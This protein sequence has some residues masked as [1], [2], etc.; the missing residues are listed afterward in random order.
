MTSSCLQK[1]KRI[2]DS[3]T[4]N[5]NIQS[6]YRN[7]IWHRK[8][9]HARNEKRKKTKNG[10]NKTVKWRKNQNARRIG[11]LQVLGNIGCR[12]HQTEIRFLKYL[13]RVS[14]ANEKASRNQTLQQESPQRKKNTWTVLIRY[15]GTFLK[16]I[17]LRL[18]DLRIRKLMMMCKALHLRYDIDYV[19]RQEG[20]RGF[21][22]SEDS[23]DASFEYNIKKEQ[24][25]TNYGNQ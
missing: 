8:M 2:G 20:G 1:R 16:W 12:H 24:R 3:G 21:A 10:S 22:S 11:K 18:M 5:K 19:S 14:Q 15:S 17:E 23:V 13:K 25:K 9:C 6:G 4:T 7:G